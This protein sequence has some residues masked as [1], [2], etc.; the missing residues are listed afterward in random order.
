MTPLNPLKSL[1]RRS[2]RRF[3]AA[4]AAVGRKSLKNRLRRC[5]GGA[6]GCTPIP[7]SKRRP[8]GGRA[9]VTNWLRWQTEQKGVPAR[10][11]LA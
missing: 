2:V 6:W 8:S 1:L 3:A 11:P 10:R 9:C 7:L 5:C 4:V